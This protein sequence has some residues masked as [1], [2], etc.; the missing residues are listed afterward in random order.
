MGPVGIIWPDVE[1][2]TTTY[3]TTALAARDEPHTAGVHVGATKLPG[4]TRQVIV[5]DDG[6][7]PIGD[8]RATARLGVNVW[9]PTEDEAAALA[10][11]VT[12]LL[13]AWPDGKPVLR[14]NAR[15][16][17]PVA[18]KAAPLRYLT[19]ELVVRGTTL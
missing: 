18:D 4:K 19:A 8:I 10:A 11:L 13:N 7:D 9:A 12:A 1:A 2:I 3:L 15:R 16:A 5:R 17:F 14:V 6:G